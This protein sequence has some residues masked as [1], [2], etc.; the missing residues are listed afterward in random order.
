MSK[1]EI[2][3]VV[4]MLR[5]GN[6]EN[7]SYILGVFDK[8]HSAQCAGE[9]EKTFRGCKYEPAIMTCVLNAD[10]TMD[11]IVPGNWRRQR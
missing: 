1:A 3:Y 7:H 2:L 10:M 8:K 4:E 5:Y 6:R 9:A 11:N